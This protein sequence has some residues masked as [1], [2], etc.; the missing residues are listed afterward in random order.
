MKK[1]VIVT[2][3]SGNLGKVVVDKL[4]L[5]GYHVIATVSPGKMPANNPN[6]DLSLYEADLSSEESSGDFVA[7][8]I[9][10]HKTI[11]AALLLVGSFASGTIQDTDGSKMRKMLSLNFETAYFT[12]RPVF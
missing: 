12:A 6:A 11:D 7:K 8:A 4:L 9:A 3:A 5:D 2:G 1:N 10:Q